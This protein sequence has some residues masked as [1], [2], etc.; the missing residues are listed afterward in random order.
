MDEGDVLAAKEVTFDPET[1]SKRQV[2][3]QTVTPVVPQVPWSRVIKAGS[4]LAGGL[5]A[6]TFIFLLLF[7]SYAVSTWQPMAL[8]YESI[9]LKVAEPGVGLSLEKITAALDEKQNILTLKGNISN[10]SK[11]N[12]ILPNLLVRLSGETGW[13]K[14]WPINLHSKFM[15]P[16]VSVGF[17]Y[18]LKDASSQGREVTLRFA[19]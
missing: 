2:T 4:G 10:H 5:L 11:E 17:E 1:T 12:K 8:L 3:R 15:P 18:N 9:G 14:D 6:V 7:K 19:D 13:L 16:N